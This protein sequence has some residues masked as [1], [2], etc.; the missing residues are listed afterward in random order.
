VALCWCCHRIV[1]AIAIVSFSTPIVHNFL[2][3]PLPVGFASS[4]L[5]AVFRLSWKRVLLSFSWKRVLL[6]FIVET[7]AVSVSVETRAVSVSVETGAVSVSSLIQQQ[8]LIPLTSWH[9]NNVVI[10]MLEIRFRIHI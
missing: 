10:D 6:P 3:Y 7:R 4:S 2:W 5:G 8:L 9:H 1:L